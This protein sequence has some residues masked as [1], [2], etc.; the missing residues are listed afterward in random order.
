[1]K[2]I[3]LLFLAILMLLSLAACDT[4]EPT[5]TSNFSSTFQESSCTTEVQT[6]EKETEEKSEPDY[7]YDLID[8]LFYNSSVGMD[9]YRSMP[10]KGGSIVSFSKEDFAGEDYKI[11]GDT[12]ESSGYLLSLFD[13]QSK[14]LFPLCFDPICQHGQDECFAGNPL[15]YSQAC[16]V[17]NGKI[18]CS[19]ENDPISVEVYALDG[20]LEKK[21]IFDM[22]SLVTNDGSEAPDISGGSSFCIWDETL[23]IDV[24]GYDQQEEIRNMRREE[25]RPLNR[26]IVAFDVDTL[27]FRVVCNYRVADPYG[28]NFEFVECNGAQL[29]IDYDNRYAYCINLEDGTYTETD[30]AA[31]IDQVITNE[32]LSEGTINYIEQIYPLSGII[33]TG[34]NARMYI[35]V[36]SAEILTLS[37]L[38]THKLDSEKVFKCNGETY[39]EVHP[40]E[41]VRESNGEEIKV[42][43]TFE[44]RKYNI[45][46]EWFGI[47]SENGIIYLY[48]DAGTTFMDDEYTVEEDG[49]MVTYKKA[50]RY[51]YVT[52]EDMLDGQI[53]EP[54]YY[55]AET[56]MF[57][58]K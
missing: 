35:S 31:I 20:T 6:S 58:Q 53:D 19:Y 38:E 15:L 36:D 57:V 55:D 50:S 44:D 3:V 11:L 2:R 25:N 51:I 1:M 42:S 14:L 49:V 32:S 33:N 34:G 37:T 22:D 26:W 47:K 13:E 23:Y 18:Y 46:T 41:Y 28:N 5:G 48:R 40:L 43:A 27:E 12:I 54:W 30:C 45:A 10:I 39:Y 9:I 8:Y 17:A 21:I 4:V 24:W 52:Y 29:G 7:R 16:F 56:G